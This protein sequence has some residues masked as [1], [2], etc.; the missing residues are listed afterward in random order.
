M[1]PGRISVALL[2]SVVCCLV[3]AT[4]APGAAPSG[5]TIHVRH[6]EDR[7]GRAHRLYGYVFSRDAKR[8]AE[9]RHMNVYRQRGK[10]P[11]FGSDEIV[12]RDLFAHKDGGRYPWRLTY[13]SERIKV[14]ERYYAWVPK[15]R[16][17]EHDRSKT[18]RVRPR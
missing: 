6:G 14:G 4:G 18:I 7:P 17:C 3:V 8:C 1:R 9:D 16:G 15:E 12:G 2:L 10:T 11:H 13:P 5:V